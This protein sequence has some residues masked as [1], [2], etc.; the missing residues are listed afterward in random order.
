MD[1]PN[2]SIWGHRVAKGLQEKPKSW[3]LLTLATHYWRALGYP[4][5][6]IDCLRRALHYSSK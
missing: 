5:K 1:E 6:A 4:N 3:V 2:P